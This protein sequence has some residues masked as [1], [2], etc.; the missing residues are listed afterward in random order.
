VKEQ[1][2]E[3]AVQPSES[4][5]RET[6]GTAR[7]V[8]LV[9]LL[10]ALAGVI[11]V[12]VSILATDEPWRHLSFTLL[13][14]GG[15]IVLQVIPVRLSHE[16]QGE[17]L[18][19]EEAF[20]VAMV[21]YL[22]VPETLTALGAAVIIG[23][24]YHRRGWM[25]TAFNTGQLVVATAVGAW[26]ARGLGVGVEGP[27]T[28]ALAVA[29]LG[30]LGYSVLSMLAVAG[31]ISVVQKTPFRTAVFDGLD[32]RVA[33][34]I[35]SI[36]I[37]VMIAVA[38][39]HRP[40][41]VPV[42]TVPVAMLQLTYSRSFRQYRER[43][44]LEK[45]YRASAD[46]RST[47]DSQRVREHLLQATRTVLDAG[48]VRLTPTGARP[49]PGALRAPLDANSSLEVSDRVGGGSWGHDDEFLLRALASVAANALSQASLFEQLRTITGSLA[50]GVISVDQR[51]R[52]EFVNP[53]VEQI[54]GWTPD[55]LLGRLPHQMVHAGD[56]PCGGHCPMTLPLSAGSTR[57]NN[58]DAFTR[59][60]G[61]LLPV[62]HTTSPVIRDGEVIGAVITFH[63][64]AERKDFER[65]LTHQA[66][67]DGLTGLPNRA[68]FLDR[69]THA[70]ERG[71]RTGMLYSLLFI[72]LDRFKVV[73]D[74]LGHQVGDELL[75]QVAARLR[76]CL[77][78]GD[79]L[80]RFGGDE[81]VAL[82]EDVEDEEAAL[83]VTERL[84]ADLRRPFS[85]AG[86]ALTVSCSIGV[87][88]GDASPADADE[89]LR[90]GD[91]AMYRAKARGKARYEVF[92]P[93]DDPD[94]VERLDLEIELRG[95]LERGEF[96][97]HYQPIVSTETGAITGIEAL[98]RW[99]HPER[100]LV[101]PDAFIPL[102]EETGLILPLGRWILEEACRQMQDWEQNCPRVSGLVM[103]VN[104]SPRQFR[105]P[106]LHEQ[107]AAVLRHSG[108]D[109]R[110]LCIEVTE[111]VM[112]DD[113]ESATL[114]LRKLKALGISVSIDDFG[115][116]YSSLSYLQRFPIDYVKIDRS[117]IRGLGRETVD[118]EI[119][120]SVIRLAAAIGIQ[121][122][123]EGVENEEQLR[124]LESL[125]C[126]LVQGYHLARPQPAEE[127]EKVLSRWSGERAA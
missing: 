20:L 92:R 117:F 77:R 36:A 78:A 67:H 71:A 21:V 124:Q 109:A 64:I 54:L 104:L 66:F 42:V 88:M 41:M 39:E 6:G 97:L 40:W 31:I 34:W 74:S 30:V 2:T 116:G 75:V 79:T 48:T 29:A 62:A 53:A 102:A 28:H 87:V 123:A 93:D 38:M 118:S 114:T 84:L 121:S 13:L 127:T 46:I 10:S 18:H 23:G 35:G 96:E 72:D 63:D 99:R 24:L 82:L 126:P 12:G 57:R 107:V 68:L 98:V 4:E 100:G 91:V 108:L 94:Q 105:Q 27:T 58:D 14:A 65:Q 76:G 3:G 61:S 119:V 9:C 90:K 33:A 19:L 120:R 11:A 83:A 56:R 1:E 32:V 16:G 69:L 43:R 44:Q 17:N 50:E 111:G 115:T 86:R 51:G 113:V 7:L 49:A 70:Q 22:T 125:G 60:D 52:I 81:F 15:A 26:V 55:D 47:I 73:N 103:S 89:C 25:K 80:A 110:Q 106:D 101:P 5:E 112:V 37:G 85:V 8:A 122:V 45:L 95:A 59:K